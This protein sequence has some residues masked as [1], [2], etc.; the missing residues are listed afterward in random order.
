MRL[1]TEGNWG[2][3]GV[4]HQLLNALC[5]IFS[6]SCAVMKA[7]ES[8]VFLLWGEVSGCCMLCASADNL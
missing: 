5:N 7:V 4:R 2:M 8:P 3:A 6:L 1:E